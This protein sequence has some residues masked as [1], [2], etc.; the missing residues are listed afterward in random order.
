M[1]FDKK[2][3]EPLNLLNESEKIIVNSNLLY[4]NKVENL[5]AKLMFFII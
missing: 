3:N 2:I 5:R 1:Y 4:F